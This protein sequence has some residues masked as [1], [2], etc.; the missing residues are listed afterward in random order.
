MPLRVELAA[1]VLLIAFAAPATSGAEPASA[2]PT[3]AEVD[4]ALAKLKADPNLAAERTIR[5]LKWDVDENEK[6]KKKKFDLPSWLR[7]I[8]DLF[9]WIA[10]T[11]RV[12]VWVVIAALIASIVIFVV[13]IFM[14][15][16][17]LG[18]AAKF[19]A[20][21]HVQDL[22]I[23]PESLPDDV[24]AAA[25][26]LWDSGDR[27]AALA[28]LYRGMLSRLAHVHE[29]PIRASSTEGD[30]LALAARKLDTARIDY[31]TRL[32]RSWQRAIY[33]GVTLDTPDVH[34]LCAQFATH[35]DP[36]PAPSGGGGLSE[37]TT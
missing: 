19:V 17:N 14:G 5:S 7:W 28:L 9:G 23:R 22:D 34:M 8:G 11:S 26:A 32:V 35:L 20:P 3:S 36:Q 1:L 33:G 6:K 25:R 21:T 10:Q 29:V 27:R 12:L 30:C 31:V 4:T 13:R 37:A 18:L 24:G 15:G 2:S 16:R